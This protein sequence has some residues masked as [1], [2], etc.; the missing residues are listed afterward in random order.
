MP[1]RPGQRFA[2]KHANLPSK[3]STESSRQLDMVPS[4]SISSCPI[5]LK[6][7][8]FLKADLESRGY[9]SPSYLL[10][11]EQLIHSAARLQQ[12]NSEI[13]MSGILIERRNS[14]GALTGEVTAHP[15]LSEE[16]NLSAHLLKIAAKF[17]MTPADIVFLARTDP[18]ANTII[19]AV[20]TETSEKIV[21]FRD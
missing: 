2:G 3:V 9:W 10:V 5:K 21:Y 13:E 1:T 8:N 17:G 6:L 14:N 18:A 20:A 7:W 16:R 15:L 11:L 4:E 19:E 12:V